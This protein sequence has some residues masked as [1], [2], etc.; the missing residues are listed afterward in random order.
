MESVTSLITHPISLCAYILSLAFGLVA[1]KKD[2]RFFYLAASLS[3]V[4]LVGGLFL[5]WQQ[6]NKI[7][8]PSI[9]RAPEKMSAATPS[10]ENKK[11]PSV[12]PT[13]NQTSLGNQSPNISGTKGD[14]NVT[15]G[16]PK[17]SSTEPKK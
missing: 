7:P 11:D 9:P 5:A 8:N 14:V 15:F 4:A 2:N 16:N 1:K 13:S 10:V 17:S 6:T 12:E 3:V